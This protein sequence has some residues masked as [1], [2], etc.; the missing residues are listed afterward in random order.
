MIAECIQVVDD[1]MGVA[2]GEA[3]VELQS[4]GRERNARAVHALSQCKLS[5]SRRTRQH[6]C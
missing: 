1:G 3:A 6:P 2:K 5:A 4:V